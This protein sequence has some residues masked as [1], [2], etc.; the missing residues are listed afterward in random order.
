MRKINLTKGYVALVDDNDF[1]RVNQFSWQAHV[2][3]YKSEPKRVR[4]VSATRRVYH[5]ETQTQTQQYM[6]R[7]ILRVTDPAVEV[8]HKNH[9]GLDNR[10]NNIRKASHANNQQHCRKA[11]NN[12]SGYKGVSWYGSRNK[13]IAI[14]QCEHHFMHLGYF[15][16]KADAAKAYDVAAREHHGKFAVTNFKEN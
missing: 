3:F 5:K 14:I 4:R 6:H 10:R 8:D 11:N 7:F 1:D 2:E 15:D 12:T 13:W 16:N 9:N